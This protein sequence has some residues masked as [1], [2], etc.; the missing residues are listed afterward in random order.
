MRIALLVL[1]PVLA[2]GCIYP[3]YREGEWPP[4]VP[5]KSY[6]L[7]LYNADRDNQKH[8]TV[9]EFLTWVIRFYKGYSIAPGWHRVEKTLSQDLSNEE[10]S[11]LAPR[12][13]FLGQLISG[14]WAK[15]TDVRLIDTRM[16]SLWGGI[17]R[18]A[19]KKKVLKR[20]IDVL[21]GDALAVLAGEVKGKEITRSRY[22]SLFTVA[23]A[24][25]GGR[26]RTSQ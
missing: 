21:H 5:H 2:A 6:Y 25:D 18:K 24:Q 10:F 8:Q 4:G 12:L 3:E 16:L 1:V 22:D 14:E 17:L 15:H 13:A 7:R 11:M 19:M 23:Q 9:E 26:T 20:A